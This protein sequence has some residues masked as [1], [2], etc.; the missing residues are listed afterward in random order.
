MRTRYWAEGW[1]YV[2]DSTSRACPIAWVPDLLEGKLEPVVLPVAHGAV[3]AFAKAVDA[4][5]DVGGRRGGGRRCRDGD[6]VAQI[7]RLVHRADSSMCRHDRSVGSCTRDRVRCSWFSRS[8][9][10]KAREAACGSRV[11]L[12]FRLS[13]MDS[14]TPSWAFSPPLRDVPPVPPAG[15]RDG[16]YNMR[17]HQIITGINGTFILPYTL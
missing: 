16:G 10:L 4:P 6:S 15:V 2:R 9:M 17:P 3:E 8:P 13:P 5:L 12:C 7:G 1:C 11:F 14:A